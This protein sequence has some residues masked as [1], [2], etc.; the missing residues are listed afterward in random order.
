MAARRYKELVELCELWSAVEIK[1]PVIRSLGAHLRQQVE[2]AFQGGKANTVCDARWDRI[3]E[4]VRRLT[5][6]HYAK[7]YP[8]QINN[9]AL[10]LSREQLQKELAEVKVME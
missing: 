7:A 5:D 1:I 8:R 3:T 4:S 2:A 6:N 10:G 9:S